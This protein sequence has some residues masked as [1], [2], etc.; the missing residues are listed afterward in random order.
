MLEESDNGDAIHT[1]APVSAVESD[2]D[3]I[4]NEC[5]LDPEM[6]RNFARQSEKRIAAEHRL[7]ELQKDLNRI[8]KDNS[9][10]KLKSMITLGGM[11]LEIESIQEDKQFLMQKRFELNKKLHASEETIRLKDEELA[12]LRSMTGEV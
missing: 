2:A 6:T 8:R 12:T 9:M 4:G 3:D 5:D 11:Q 10:L 7:L 1:T